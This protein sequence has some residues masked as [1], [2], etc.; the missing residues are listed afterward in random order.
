VEIHLIIYFLQMTLAGILE[1][2]QMEHSVMLRILEAAERRTQAVGN[3]EDRHSL[4]AMEVVVLVSLMAEQAEAVAEVQVVAVEVPKCFDMP[5][6]SG[7][8][9]RA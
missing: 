3:L 9:V 6:S 4:L 8:V 2:V 5:R 7:Q 1:V